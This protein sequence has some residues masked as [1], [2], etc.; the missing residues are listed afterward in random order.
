MDATDIGWPILAIGWFS[1]GLFTLAV[2]IAVAKLVERKVKRRKEYSGP[3]PAA[4]EIAY[5]NGGRDR[6]IRAALAA[7]DSGTAL[8]N[9]VAE[10][11]AAGSAGLSLLTQPVQDALA[12]ILR[13][14]QQRRLADA[15]GHPT[16]NGVAATRDARDL[17]AHLWPGYKPDW[18]VCSSDE[19]AMA[20]AVF[21]DAVLD[22]VDPSLAAAY[23]LA[24]ETP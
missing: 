24:V 11:R 18:A 16:P 5:L 22:A 2:V 6:A 7:H 8:R 9:A 12:D 3:P 13:S 17:Y 4:E 1:T 10:A 21:G 15:S 23:P 14:L 20:V 19:R